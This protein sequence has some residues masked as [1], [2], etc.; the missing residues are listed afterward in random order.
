MRKDFTL[1]KLAQTDGKGHCTSHHNALSFTPMATTEFTRFDD[2]LL[3]LC[4]AILD[5]PEYQAIQ[6]AID[7]FVAHPES[8]KK[9]AAMQSRGE[10]LRDRQ[11]RGEKLSVEEISTFETDRDALFEEPIIREFFDAQQ[12]AHRI[13]ARAHEVIAKT[14]ELGRLPEA[15]DFKSGCCGDSGCGC[16]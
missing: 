11:M 2:K 16:S 1:R 13:Q 4:Q 15:E 8:Q 6:P 12:F 10:Q 7:R 3:E 5:D 14:F 9:L